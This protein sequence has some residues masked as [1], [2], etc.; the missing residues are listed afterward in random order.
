[1]KRSNLAKTLTTKVNF[2]PYPS[3]FIP[4]FCTMILVTGSTGIVGTRIMFDLL[5]AGEQ[6]RALKRHNSD[7]EF[8]K[9]V[10]IFYDSQSGNSLFNKIE[11]YNADITDIQAL[12]SAFLGITHCYHAAA[13]VSYDPNDREKLLEI[14]AE[15]TENLVNI[16]LEVGVLKICHISSVSALGRTKK[17][18]LITENDFWNRDD[19]NS[20][21]GLSKF[22]AEREVWRGTAEGLPAVIVNPSII[23][24]PSKPNKS[25]GMLMALLQK[26]LPFYPTGKAGYVDVRDVSKA[27]IL[28]MN[29]DIENKRFILN[30]ENLSYN[31]LLCMAA[32]TF[33]NKPPK[34]KLQPWMLSL[35]WMGAKIWSAITGNKSK[36]TRETARSASKENVFS[37]SKIR[38]AISLDFSAV[39]ASLLYYQPFFD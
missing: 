15:G 2:N 5:K 6:V 33:G 10:F 9:R 31:K 35:G 1:M 34:I 30:S 36:L 8:V 26:G 27:C 21:Y 28:L 12:E 13:L 23:L 39:E 29:S 17:G 16:A 25:S 7:T 11:W 24:G 14:N 38:E 37:N 3:I 18:D 22:M 19:N 4:Y 32:S 20:A